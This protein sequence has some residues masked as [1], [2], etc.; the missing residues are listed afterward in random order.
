MRFLELLRRLRRKPLDVIAVK[1]TQHARLALMEL[2]GSW[3]RLPDRAERFLDGRSGRRMLETYHAGTPRLVLVSDRAVEALRATAARRPEVKSHILSLAEQIRSRQ[4][5]ILGAQVPE[6]GP[7]PWTEDWRFGRKWENGPYRRYRFYESRSAPY[8]VKFPWELSR[9]GW[10]IHLLQAQA[11]EDRDRN[12]AF[13]LEVLRDWRSKNPAG[14]SIAWVSMEAS[15][16]AINLAFALELATV[17]PFHDAELRKL[18]L[19]EITHILYCH[20]N[21]VW[22][23]MEYT[24]V[25]G[26]HYAANLVA[27]L[28]L[29]SIFESHL[30]PARSKWLSYSI[31]LIEQEISLQFA[32][33]GVNLEK[34]VGYHRLVTELALLSVVVLRR[35][36][37]P[38]AP[39]TIDV[40]TKACEYS[41]ACRRP[42]NIAVNVGDNDDAQAIVFDGAAS[43]DHRALICLGAELF[44]KD[45]LRAVVAEGSV[46][47]PW[48]LGREVRPSS[49]VVPPGTARVHQFGS[50]GIFVWQRGQDYLWI[51]VGEVGMKGRGGHGHNDLL[52]FELMLDGQPLFV[53]SGTY[54]YTGDL[55]ARN[56]FRSTSAHNTLAVDDE[57][58]ADILGPWR[59]SD[60]ARPVDVECTET[61][62]GCLVRASHTGYLRLSDPVIVRRVFSFSVDARKLT[63]TDRLQ[64]QGSHRTTRWLH[65]SPLSEVTLEAQSAIVSLGGKNYSVKWSSQ[66]TVSIERHW[67]SEHYGH[68]EL[69]P[70]IVLRQGVSGDDAMFIEVSKMGRS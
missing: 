44:D 9:L 59:I 6:A 47:V 61:P 36:G 43:R 37:R 66:S 24:D 62:E 64:C 42:D 63:V 33:D 56:W 48:I 30:P 7:W 27:L 32:S 11:L 5:D 40:L 41:A 20:G 22:R 12:A 54:L 29:G 2:G 38:I 17:V 31:R 8:D 45:P 58:I 60:Q 52:S 50:G 23:N 34:S 16:R 70:V 14:Y 25:R 18:L 21:F 3:A 13:V 4:F 69:A 65:L 46:S 53:D 26:N 35:I 15:M 39:R 19:R 10:I 57:E 68:R 49:K 1:G 51:D 67:L 55:D 28:I